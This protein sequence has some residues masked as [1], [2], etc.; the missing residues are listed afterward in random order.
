[1]PRTAKPAK[2]RRAKQG[3]S[4]R[5]TEI[6]RTTVLAAA[7]REFAQLGLAGARVDRIAQRAG[8]NKQALYYHYGSKEDLFRATL[9]S[10]YK[11]A[12]PIHQV[13][14]APGLSPEQA[15]RSL[16]TALFEH[17][18]RIE[19]GTSVIA[20]ENRY[21]GKH[22]TPKIRHQIR[23]A[24]APII[25]AIENVLTRGQK[26]GV[27]AKNVTVANLYLTL[28]AQSMFYFSHAYTLSAI[29]EY[30]L[31]SDDAV[32]SWKSHVEEFVLAALRPTPRRKSTR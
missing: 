15:M 8:V 26:E 11:D 13:W 12:M 3:K 19:D 25:D 14:N 18:R 17:F 23:A 24:I 7:L 27:F 30:D 4:Q 29:L 10:V 6:T 2:S 20:H 1:M 16:I 21:H 5:R 22:L 28:I 9:A 31:L 32:E